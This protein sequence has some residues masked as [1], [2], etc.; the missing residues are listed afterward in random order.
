MKTLAE[1][2]PDTFEGALR[3]LAA[4]GAAY[5]TKVALCL[6]G[7][8]S[9]EPD[10][11]TKPILAIFFTSPSETDVAQARQ[12]LELLS[13]GFFLEASGG[14][15]PAPSVNVLLAKVALGPERNTAEAL[16][17]LGRKLAK[18]FPARRDKL[19]LAHSIEA[20][21]R[22]DPAFER[23]PTIGR[24]LAESELE[25]KVIEL[26]KS[27]RASAKVQAALKADLERLEADGKAL[28]EAH[29]AAA[30]AAEAATRRADELE[31]ALAKFR[32]EEGE[33]PAEGEGEKKPA[34]T[35]GKAK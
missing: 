28:R 3:V 9:R 5:A 13:S 17:A 8:A 30:K 19:E 12:Q 6:F 21:L 24:D 7:A 1:A 31:A 33:E 2:S 34:K 25:D 10:K 23:A 18:G 26:E 14:T 11:R 16:V 15:Q 27:L 32:L 20:R 29:E 35:K 4:R 22:E